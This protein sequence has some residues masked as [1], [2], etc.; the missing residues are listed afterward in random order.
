MNQLIQ[1][2]CHCESMIALLLRRSPS[3]SLG[4][5][6]GMVSLSNHNLTIIKIASLR[7]CPINNGVA[8]FTMT[9]VTYKNYFNNALSH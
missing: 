5:V 4:M 2:L 9:H 1:Y 8:P 7:S 3:T 6:R